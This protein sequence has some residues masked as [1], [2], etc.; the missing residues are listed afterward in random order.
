MSTIFSFI[1]T[2]LNVDIEKGIRFYSN[3]NN[4]LMFSYTK[5]IYYSSKSIYYV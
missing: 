5:S 1:F 2:T 4:Y 3:P